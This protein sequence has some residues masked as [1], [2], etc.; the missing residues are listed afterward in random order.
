MKTAAEIARDADGAV[1]AGTPDATATSW[2]FDSRALDAGACFVALRGDRDGHEFV[3]AAF[4]AGASVA[5]VSTPAPPSSPPAG[6]AMVEVADALRGLQAVAAADRRARADLRVVGVTGST[7]KTSTKDLLAAVLAPLGCYASPASY[8]NEFGLPDHAAQRAGRS[9]T[10]SSPRWGSGSP[11]TSRRCARSRPEIG[12]VT[13]VGL[14]HAEH[15]G[16][17]AGAA[18]A[19]GELIEAL[20]AGGLAVLNADDEWTPTLAARAPVGG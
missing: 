5:L 13:N 16:G 10:W 7:G 3:P 15:L 4:A 2:A 8:N 20:P 9:R 6:A 11:A 1:V 18:E 12:V 19:I 17:P 14:A